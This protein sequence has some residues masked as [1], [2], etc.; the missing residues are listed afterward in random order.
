MVSSIANLE[1]KR[2]DLIIPPPP[3]KKGNNLAAA[4]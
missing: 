4:E 2:K 1:M 3:K